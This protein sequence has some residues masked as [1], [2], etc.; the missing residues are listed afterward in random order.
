MFCYAVFHHDKQVRVFPFNSVGDDWK[1][2]RTL[3]I[4][5][6][7]SANTE[8]YSVEYFGATEVGITIWK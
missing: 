3:A 2:A 8:G 7:E 4:A 1:R 5:F 6:A